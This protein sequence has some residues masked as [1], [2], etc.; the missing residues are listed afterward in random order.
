[1]S[2]DDPAKVGLHCIARQQVTKC[3]R[4]GC[5]FTMIIVG[6]S[7]SGRTTLMNTL[8]GAEIF[9]YDTL[10]HGSF[11]R[12][13]CQLCEDEVN[14]Q[15]SLID[16]GGLHPSEYSYSSVARYIDAQH[17][18]HIFQEEQPKRNS[19]KDNRIHCCLFFI[20]PKIREI[21]S[22]ELNAMRELSTRVNLVPIL[23]KCDTFSPAELETIKIRV[24]ETLQQN[25]IVCDLSSDG[26]Y[27]DMTEQVRAQMPYA[28]IGSNQVHPNYEGNMV[29][30]RKYAWGLAEVENVNHCDFVTLRTL[31]MTNHMLDFIQSTE[32]HYEKFREFCLMKRLDYFEKTYGGP[33]D[34]SSSLSIYAGYHRVSM[35]ITSNNL[36]FEDVSLRGKEEE[37][38]NKITR[39]VQ[40]QESK[41]KEWKRELVATQD[42]LNNDIDQMQEKCH[43]LKREIAMYE[44]SE[45]SLLDDT[46]S[47]PED[48]SLDTIE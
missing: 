35:E 13:E 24:R 27:Q 20:S 9:P 48:M 26:S 33:V 12:Y 40:L 19:L 29:R 25:S 11:R 43:Q 18:Q 34:K 16:T 46:L 37:I 10:E 44:S 36:I 6:A 28:V 8:F 42:F 45:H 21:S 2:D 15:V 1:M 4:E 23:G 31:L 5:R 30:G 3:A 47:S 39:D 17:F 32:V 38:K 14:L 22:H 41:F 7:G